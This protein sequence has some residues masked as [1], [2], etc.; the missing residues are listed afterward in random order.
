M[1]NRWCWAISWPRSQVSDLASCGGRVVIAAASAS[2][3]ASAWWLPPGSE[4]SIRNRVL[5]ST[6]VATGLMCLAEDQVALPVPGHRSVLGFGRPLRRCAACSVVHPG[7][8]A[9]ALLWGGGSPGRC[10]DTG[11]APCAAHHGTARRGC[12]RCSRATPASP[13]AS[14]RSASASRRSAAATSDGPASPPRWHA[15]AG[16]PAS[17]HALG[18]VARDH[19]AR[20]ARAARYRPRPPLALTSRLIVEGALPNADSDRPDRQPG[21]QA[22]GD[23]LPL[24]HAQPTRCPPPRLRSD[25][26]TPNQIRPHRA[27]C[28]TPAPAPSASPPDRPASSTTPGRSPP[29][30]T[31]RNRHDP[32][33]PPRHSRIK[34]VL[35]RPLETAGMT[36]RWWLRDCARL[37]T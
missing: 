15:A 4:T 5:R 17:L 31:A 8:R 7:R 20:S 14:G 26:A 16:L 34:E 3:T 10:A 13:D 30:S 19:A 25:P 32:Q 35:R 24:R 11:S 6:R 27:R 28:T 29:A 1:V 22:A 37:K 9:A 23:L 18:R 21:R 12:G 2:A 36:V 33:R